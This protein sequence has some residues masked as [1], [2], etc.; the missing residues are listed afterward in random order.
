MKL[1]EISGTK[2]KE[3]LKAKFETNNET[4]ISQNLCKGISDLRRVTSPE[5]IQ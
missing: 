3:Y 4:K 1:V 5:L 2:K